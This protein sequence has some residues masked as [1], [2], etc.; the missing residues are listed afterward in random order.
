MEF[1][2][3][4]YLAKFGFNRFMSLSLRKKQKLFRY[5]SSSN[6]SVTTEEYPHS[7]CVS[8]EPVNIISPYF[9]QF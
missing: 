6:F 9:R 2:L 1:D 8:D 7:S 4:K 5:I 3:N